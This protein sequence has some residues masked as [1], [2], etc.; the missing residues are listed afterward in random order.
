MLGP[1]I[2]QTKAE[3]L[4]SG[5]YGKLD[6]KTK[7]N[8]VRNVQPGAI[9]SVGQ[10]VSATA[11]IRD[12]IQVVKGQVLAD[13]LADHP[14]P[15]EW[16]LC[17]ELPDD[18]MNVKVMPPWQMYFNGAAYQEDVEAR[19]VFIMPQQDLLPYSFSLSHKCSNNVAEY[20]ALILGLE[21]AADL[22][23]AQLKIY[24]DSY[25]IIR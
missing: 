22:N 3:A 4:F 13:F 23:V 9:R 14:L 5:S 10:M 18:I 16:E 2:F 20:Q 17:D 24:E 15:A 6:L 11:T 21:A 25:L 19:V 7:S 8:Q 1:D 12:C